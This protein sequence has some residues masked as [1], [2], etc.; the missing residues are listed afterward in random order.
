ME[1]P[2]YEE[3]VAILKAI[4]LGEEAPPGFPETEA[5]LRRE[6][7]EIVAA[8]GTPEIPGE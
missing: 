6:V 4:L 3:T 2:T 7:D 8:G 5:A 1:S